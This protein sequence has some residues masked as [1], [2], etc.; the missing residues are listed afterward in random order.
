[1]AISDCD[2]SELIIYAASASKHRSRRGGVNLAYTDPSGE[3]QRAPSHVFEEGSAKKG[4]GSASILA[5][6]DGGGTF[7]CFDTVRA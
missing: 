7:T 5:V 4:L 1:M 3:R 6:C 2:R